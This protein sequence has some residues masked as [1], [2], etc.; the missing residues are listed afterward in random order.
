MGC[1]GYCECATCIRR[2]EDL[3]KEIDR[4]KTQ[5][6]RDQKTLFNLLVKVT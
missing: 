5:I 3:Q 1:H 2:E 6:I 4:L